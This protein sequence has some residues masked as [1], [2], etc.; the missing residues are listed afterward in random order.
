MTI[1]EKKVFEEFCKE[2]GIEG[3]TKELCR[4]AFVL[5]TEEGYDECDTDNAYERMFGFDC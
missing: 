5:G 2:N 1:K 3:E 4:K